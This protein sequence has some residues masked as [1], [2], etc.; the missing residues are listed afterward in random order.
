M[1]TK[2]L[3]ILCLQPSKFKS[4][5]G[6]LE[7]FFLTVG[8]KNFGNKLPFI[9]WRFHLTLKAINQHKTTNVHLQP[10]ILCEIVLINCLYMYYCLFS[11]IFLSFF[12]FLHYGWNLQIFSKNYENFLQ[13]RYGNCNS[14]RQEKCNLTAYPNS[15]PVARIFIIE[16]KNKLEQM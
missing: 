5:S 1:I 4:F 6:S 10:N 2:L 8:Q 7:Q 11:A 12:L 15:N 14:M 16:R 3:Q 9:S 13:Y